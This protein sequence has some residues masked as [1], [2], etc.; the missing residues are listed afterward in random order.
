M[1]CLQGEVGAGKV[2]MC[3]GW[4]K[5]EVERSGCRGMEVWRRCATRCWGWGKMRAGETSVVAARGLEV[6]AEGASPLGMEGEGKEGIVDGTP[7]PA[8]V[9][10]PLAVIPLPGALAVSTQRIR[11]QVRTRSRAHPVVANSSTCR[12]EEE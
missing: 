1:V 5:E 3:I 6:V 2:Q 9:P 12:S 7:F 10:G 4:R 11:A 8:R